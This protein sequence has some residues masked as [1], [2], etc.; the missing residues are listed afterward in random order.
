[1]IRRLEAVFRPE[2]K[3][4]PFFLSMV[5]FGLAYGLYKG[6]IDN[7]LA[8][9]V[10]M[11]G[12][13]KGVSE[14]FRELPGLMLIFILAALYTFSAERIYKLGALFMLAGMAAHLVERSGH[15]VVVRG[16][17][18]IHPDGRGGSPVQEP[19]RV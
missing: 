15:E 5:T 9:I 18:L 11:S 17:D 7:Y 16:G 2:S 19:F 1:M 3:Y 10:G 8:E 13:D 6:V 14:F 12:F 4:R